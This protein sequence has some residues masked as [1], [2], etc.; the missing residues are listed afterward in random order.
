[1]AA[2][3]EALAR[4]PYASSSATTGTSTAL[5]PESRTLLRVEVANSGASSPSLIDSTDHTASWASGAATTSPTSASGSTTAATA[6]SPRRR[7]GRTTSPRAA[8][9]ACRE[10]PRARRSSTSSVSVTDTSSIANCIAASRSNAMNQ[11]R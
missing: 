9:W 3:L 5:I 2:V 6:E 11:T 8:S 10:R 1:M 4:T 7:T